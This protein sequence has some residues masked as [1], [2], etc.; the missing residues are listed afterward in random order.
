VRG[1]GVGRRPVGRGVA[2]PR[3]EANALWTRRAG[4]ASYSGTTGRAKTV[5]GAMAAADVAVGADV[6]EGSVVVGSRRDG[7]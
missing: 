4:R 1:V 2:R 7:E 5:E 6:E 3:W